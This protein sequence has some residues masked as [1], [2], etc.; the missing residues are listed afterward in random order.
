MLYKK[1]KIISIIID[2]VI[3]KGMLN[4][5][6]D[7]S[8]ICLNYFIFWKKVPNLKNPQTFSEKIQWIKIYGDLGKYSKY[9]DK[10]E[11]RKYVTETVGKKYLIPL[12][13]VWEKVEEIDFNKLPNKFIIQTTHGKDYNF[14]CKD[15]TL[16][17]K[18]KVKKMLKKWVKQNY[19]QTAREVQYKH[20]KP[21]IICLKYLEDESGNLND[22]KFFCNKGE[23]QIIEVITGN[24]EEHTLDLLDLNWGKLPIFLAYPNSKR[25]PK[26]PK[27]L[28]KM[29]NLS[30]KLSKS[31]PFVRVD[32]YSVNNR[33]Y[34]GELT[35]TPGSGLDLIKPNK[36]NYE[37]GK[38]IDLSNFK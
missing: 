19:Y 37:L 32:L 11:V 2:I 20:I 29:I 35:F 27:N 30:K 16:L 17:D 23:P 28:Q 7:K 14:I 18:E 3:K 36:A 5:L 31:F 26:K 10:Y 12:I 22:Y 15:K 8:A 25:N 9:A 6:S 13:G 21:K 33:I 34:F 38:L 1:N 24:V 4:L